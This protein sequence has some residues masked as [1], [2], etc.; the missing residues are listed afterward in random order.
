VRI[1]VL[2]GS[3]SSTPELADALADWPGGLDR[4]PVLDVVLHGRSQDKLEVVAAE[5]RARAG[6]AG[7]RLAVTVATDRRAALDGAD[8]VINQVRI[9]GLDARVFDETFPREFGLPGEE[10]MGPGGFANAMRTVPALVSTWQDI[11]EV[12]PDCLVVNLTNPAG[13]VHQ[14]M[15]AGWPRLTVVTVCDA[16][17]AFARRIADV[18]ER[19]I[20]RVLDRYA[21][22]N[23]VGFYI[24]EDPAERPVLTRLVSGFDPA[25]VD[26]FGALPTPYVRYYLEPAAQLE[27]QRQRKPRAEE[28]KA[29]DTA[30]LSAYASGPAAERRKRGAVWYELVVVPALDGWLHGSD[31]PW[32]VGTPNDG[33]IPCVPDSTMIEVA[34]TF[35]PGRLVPRPIP[36]LPALVNLWL[37]RHGVYEKLAADAI[38][39]AG[40]RTALLGAMTANPLVTSFAQADGLLTA[41][42]RWTA[43]H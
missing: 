6:T 14:A 29:I 24:P 32:V 18:L 38:A 17:E 33:R 3:G 7:P 5:F 23:H 42:E 2:G 34:H 36:E 11:A 12:A 41:I 16:P 15:R 4:R 10:T 31:R 19:P 13:I 20:E 22:M 28:L 43:T 1:V 26:V 9:G 25:V 37:A 35:S 30:L 21:G 40:P 39:D 27:A 8:A